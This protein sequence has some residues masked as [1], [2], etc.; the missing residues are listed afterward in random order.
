MPR[1]RKNLPP[2]PPPSDYTGG[3]YGRLTVT[4]RDP[5]RKY[6]YLCD[7]SCGTKAKSIREDHFR[8]GRVVSCGCAKREHCRTLADAGVAARRSR[9]TPPAATE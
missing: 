4:G 2:G 8:C 7:C 5:K 1:R 6:Y 9:R 3:T